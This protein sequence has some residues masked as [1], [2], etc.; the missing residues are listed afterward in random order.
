MVHAFVQGSG[1]SGDHVTGARSGGNPTRL[2]ASTVSG[3]LAGA[4]AVSARAAEA[5]AEAPIPGAGLEEVVVTAQKRVEN[6]QSVPISILAIDSKQLADLQVASFD[7]YARY[8]PSLSVQSYGPGQAQLYVRGVTNGGDGTHLGSQPLVGLYVDEMPVTT[9]AQNLDLHVYDMARIEALSGPQGTLFGASSMAGTVRLITNKPSTSRMEGAID[10]TGEAFTAGGPGGKLEGFVNVPV[11]EQLAVRLVGW[12][13]HDGGYINVV[14]GSPQYFPTSG[15]VRDNAKLVEKNSNSVDTAGGRLAA[16]LRVGESWTVTPTI[17]TQ[18]QKAFG[19]YAYTP[20]PVTLTPTLPGGAQG[21][22]MTLGGT[23]DLNIARY[24]REINRDDWWMSTLVVQGK[25]S[26]FDLTY[27]GGFIKRDTFSSGDYSDYSLFYDVYYASSGSYGSLFVDRNGKLIDPSQ[28]VLGWNHFNKQ[29]HEL[30]LATPAEWRLHGVVGYFWQRQLDDA[31]YSYSVANL[32]PAVSVDGQPGSVW[33]ERALRTDRDRAAFTEW[34]FDLSKKLSVT[35]GIRAFHYD[36]TVNGF[37]GFGPR[38]PSPDAPY[39]GENLCFTPVQPGNPTLPCTNLDYRA[40]KSSTTHRLNLEYKFDEDRMAYLT[41]STGFR[42]GGINRSV[43]IP[44]YKPDYLANFEAGFKTS[45]WDHRLRING[46]VFY[47]RWKDAQFAYPGPNA[48]NVVINAGRAGIKGAEGEVHWRV[49]DGLT[50]ST[51]FTV[52]DP[53]LLSTVCKD[54]TV[55][56]PGCNGGKV[57]AADGTRLPV[58]SKFKGNTI[59]RYEWNLGSYRAHAQAAAVYQTDVRPALRNSDQAVL[60][61]QGGYATLDLAAGAMR[62]L[63][64]AE[65]YVQ[66][67]FDRRGESFRYTPCSPSTCSLVDVIPIR[68]RLVGLSVGRKF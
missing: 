56:T 34:T 12:G 20:F 22:P 51:S 2:L 39:A 32:S 61:M 46:A 10:V 35:G 45:W 7:D 53:K 19:Q 58:S 1:P 49:T 42:P 6:L 38:F 41:W 54:F 65:V 24:F 28:Q 18:S 29:S 43:I 11:N 60:G 47:E 16:L 8:L 64:S 48:V 40:T 52:L 63:W 57:F 31:K 55:S 14:R 25:L 26:N 5:G 36:N 15:L 37:F 30:R 67:L 66:N 23:G 9:I 59:A 27:A 33:F 13:E 44:P 50:L 62:D 17:M 4:L 21:A 68:P 3:I